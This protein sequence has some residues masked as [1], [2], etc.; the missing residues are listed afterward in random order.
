[1]ELV[2][3]SCQRCRSRKSKCVVDMEDARKPCLRCKRLQKA[4]SFEAVDQ[5]SKMSQSGSIDTPFTDTSNVS[6][7]EGERYLTESQL[8]DSLWQHHQQP[9]S[10]PLPSTLTSPTSGT[11][12]GFGGFDRDN[13]HNHS[14]ITYSMQNEENL[15]G[16]Q[17]VT[18][19]QSDMLQDQEQVKI[20]NN[21]SRPAKAEDGLR[22]LAMQ[23]PPSDLLSNPSDKRFNPAPSLVP[24]SL[25]D[26]Y[27]EVTVREKARIFQQAM[28]LKQQQELQQQQERQQ[29]EQ[30]RQQTA[31]Q[32]QQPAQQWRQLQREWRQQQAMAAAGDMPPHRRD[33]KSHLCYFQSCER[34]QEGNGFTRRW[35]LFDHMKRVHDYF[36]SDS[37]LPADAVAGPS[38]ISPPSQL[39]SLPSSQSIN[40]SPRDYIPDSSPV[41]HAMTHS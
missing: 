20:A 15:Q 32:L 9:Y 3:G 35:N 25:N 19:R 33:P 11:N 23:P 31:Q 8:L 30:Q 40:K 1:M 39:S 38:L 37:P 26:P 10:M 17:A 24:P 27:D 13:Y 2:G 22:T 14:P 34:A 7:K 29:T 12:A 21:Q 4:C 36:R 16:Q 41:P 28:E 18:Q 5:N 6:S